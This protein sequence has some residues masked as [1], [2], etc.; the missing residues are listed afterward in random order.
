M[1]CRC[2]LRL[3]L[4]IIGI[5]DNESFLSE[6]L[7]SM[8]VYPITNLTRK[9]HTNG[10]CMESNTTNASHDFHDFSKANY[11]LHWSFSTLFK[12]IFIC[13][14][15]LDENIENIIEFGAANSQLDLMLENNYKK[16]YLSYIKYDIMSYD[17]CIEH[18]ITKRF[19]HEN[20]SIDA[21]VLAEII[22]HIPKEKL[23]AVMH[24]CHRV[25]SEFGIVILTTPTP[26][27]WDGM[28]LVWPDSHEY[29]YSIRELDE[30]IKL[31]PFK[32]INE[33]TWHCRDEFKYSYKGIPTPLHKALASLVCPRKS[34]TQIAMT[35]KRS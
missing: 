25:L 29:E 14:Q 34:A 20:G 30:K 32:K 31:W 10:G 15:L 17:E 12:N 28:Q 33:M 26:R 6:S 11:N 7:V 13:D 1:T 2:L 8:M 27:K 21:I 35:L 3:R 4:I 5:L 16:E 23:D 24:E 19:P 22:E 18:D 9:Q